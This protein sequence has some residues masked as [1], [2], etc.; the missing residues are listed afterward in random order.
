M[1]HLLQLPHRIFGFDVSTIVINILSTDYCNFYETVL[2]DR[3]LM[4]TA[5]LAHATWVVYYIHNLTILNFDESHWSKKIQPCMHIIILCAMTL[6]HGMYLGEQKEV[7]EWVDDWEEE[8][9]DTEQLRQEHEELRRQHEELRQEHEDLRLQ[10][11]Q[12]RVSKSRIS[13]RTPQLTSLRRQLD[14][15][16][17][18]RRNFFRRGEDRKKVETKKLSRDLEQ[19]IEGSIAAFQHQLDDISKAKDALDM[20]LGKHD[21][22]ADGSENREEIRSQDISA[23]RDKWRMMAEKLGHLKPERTEGAATRS[24]TNMSEMCAERLARLDKM[25]ESCE[26]RRNVI[27]NV[28]AWRARAMK[29]YT[30]AAND[31][32]VNVNPIHTR[33]ENETVGNRHIPSPTERENKEEKLEISLETFERFLYEKKEHEYAKGSMDAN[34]KPQKENLVPNSDV[35]PKEDWVFVEGS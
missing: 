19:E 3:F 30:E 11:E 15:Y 18:V 27:K 22:Q 6:R 32:E 29:G 12:T 4:P 24:S 1:A 13:D 23:K 17:V 5:I 21:D 35:A 25:V 31:T 16:K 20:A 8:Q 10:H 26:R 14:Q 33:E 9:D 34:K 7:K 28:L 2:R